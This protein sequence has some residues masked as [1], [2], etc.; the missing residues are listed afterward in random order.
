M[1]AKA[2]RDGSPLPFQTRRYLQVSVD[3]PHVVEILHRIQNLVDELAGVS[4]RVET[5]FHNP[6]K[7]LAARHS[8][9]GKQWSP[10]K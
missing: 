6:V 3:D 7:Q 4:L 10:V 2:H 9:E 5:F 1:F 8:A